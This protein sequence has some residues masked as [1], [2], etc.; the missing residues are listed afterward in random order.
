MSTYVSVV[1][2]KEIVKVLSLD[3][4]TI[5]LVAIK[6]ASEQEIEEYHK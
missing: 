6:K 5:L 3:H 4:E 1:I 2:P